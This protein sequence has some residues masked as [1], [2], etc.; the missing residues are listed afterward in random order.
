[1]YSSSL[2][3]SCLSFFVLFALRVCPRESTANELTKTLLLERQK[4]YKMAALRAKKQ[5]DVEQARLHFMTS[6]VGGETETL[7]G[8]VSCAALFC[9]HL[10]S[11]FPPD[12]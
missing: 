11:L 12:I 8:C 2:C 10:N 1:M 7:R 5:G 9:I 4:E 6:K 3:V